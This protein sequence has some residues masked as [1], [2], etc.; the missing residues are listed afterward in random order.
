M[1]LVREL[2][3]RAERELAGRK[4]RLVAGRSDTDWQPERLQYSPYLTLEQLRG[5]SADGSALPG[6]PELFLLF[7]FG[8]LDSRFPYKIVRTPGAVGRKAPEAPHYDNFKSI[9]AVWNSFDS[10]DFIIRAVVDLLTSIC[11]LYFL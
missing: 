8:K 7:G 2:A 11:L 1:D 9:G 5:D 10:V 6:A 3:R 4:H